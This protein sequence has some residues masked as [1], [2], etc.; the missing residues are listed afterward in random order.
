MDK[1]TI[2][3]YDEIVE[4]WKLNTKILTNYSKF[5]KSTR[6]QSDTWFDAKEQ[7]LLKNLMR[8]NTELTFGEM[9]RWGFDDHKRHYAERAIGS[10]GKV[11]ESFAIDTNNNT[12]R[13]ELSS[14]S[15]ECVEAFLYRWNNGYAFMDV[16]ERVDL[17]LTRLLSEQGV[18]IRKGLEVMQRAEAA[19]EEVRGALLDAAQRVSTHVSASK[20]KNLADTLGLSDF[21][22]TEE[23]N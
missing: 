3:K 21:I 22:E 19:R 17:A 16:Q 7:F 23:D 13:T 10:D 12:V 11:I 14:A 5:W 15:E 2:K 6:F 1:D 8:Q 4:N 18:V 20:L 9:R